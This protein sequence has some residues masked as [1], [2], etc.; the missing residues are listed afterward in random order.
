MS[1]KIFAKINVDAAV[2]DKLKLFVTVCIFFICFIPA[3]NLS[4]VTVKFL[5]LL[6]G[7][8]N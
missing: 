3:R 4:E 7:K 6:Y 1:I 2:S 8:Q 5:K